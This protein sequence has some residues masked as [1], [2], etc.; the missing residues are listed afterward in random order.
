MN[1][2]FYQVKRFL[3]VQNLC[4]VFKLRFWK[5]RICN[6][7]TVICDGVTATL[8]LVLCLIETCEYQRILI[9]SIFNILQQNLHITQYVAC[10]NIVQ[11]QLSQLLI[12]HII[13]TIDKTTEQLKNF[14]WYLLATDLMRPSRHKI[15]NPLISK[16]HKTKPPVTSSLWILDHVWNRN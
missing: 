7:V 12:Y 5:K 8:V 15:S 14:T 4:C 11:G 1:F 10:K 9:L 6:G 16:G 3:I 13:I 2:H